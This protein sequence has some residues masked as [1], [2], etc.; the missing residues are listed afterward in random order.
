LYFLGF[1]FIYQAIHIVFHETGAAG[2]DDNCYEKFNVAG[3]FDGHCGW[4]PDL[5]QFFSV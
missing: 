1:L 4:N 5:R 3:N 2:A